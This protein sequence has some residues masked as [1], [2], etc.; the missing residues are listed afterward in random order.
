MFITDNVSRTYKNYHPQTFL[1]EFNY[2]EK[3]NKAKKLIKYG[4]DTSS[5]DEF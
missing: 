2:E 4:F 1:E 5:S 3:S